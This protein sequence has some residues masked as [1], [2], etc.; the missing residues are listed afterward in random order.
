MIVCYAP[1]IYADDTLKEGFY[2]NPQ[3]LIDS[4]PLHDLTYITVDLKAKAGQDRSYRLGVMDQHGLGTITKNGARLFSFTKGNDLLI[5]GE[6]FQHK[7]INTYTW[8]SR[9]ALSE[10]R[11]TGM[12]EKRI[13]K[14]RTIIY[15]GNGATRDQGVALLLTNVPAQAMISW[16]PVSSRIITARFLGS[17]AELSI[18]ECC[19]PPRMKHPQR[20]NRASIMN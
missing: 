15:S 6:L 5:S 20:I 10:V 9:N 2:D 17:H 7:D 19:M 3:S 8:T 13:D 11:W 12:G 18:V 4:I 1:K 14:E 16:T